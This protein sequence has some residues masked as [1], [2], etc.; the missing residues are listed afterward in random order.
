MAPYAVAATVS[1]WQY[2]WQMAAYCQHAKGSQQ[3]VILAALVQLFPATL[4][5]LCTA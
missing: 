4:Y 5:L 2:Q 1:L 3:R